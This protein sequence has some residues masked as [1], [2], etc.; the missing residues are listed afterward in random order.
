DRNTGFSS[1]NPQRL[2]LPVVIDPEYHAQAVNVANQDENSSSLLWWMRRLIALRNRFQAFSR[3]SLEILLPD[4]RKVLAFLRKCGDET[5]LVIVN[6]SRF[7]QAVELDLSAYRGAIPV[8]L[9]GSTE[10]PEVG[11]LP[12]FI[13]LGG[14]GFYWFS[15]EQRTQAGTDRR[16]P[17]VA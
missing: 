15:L 3:G 1:A 6:L 13:T 17:L 14:H 8:E 7:T 4:N 5:I 9:F 11:D 12:Y 10:F 16:P 2:Y